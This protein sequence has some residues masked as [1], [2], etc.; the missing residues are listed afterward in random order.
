MN[1]EVRE[2]SGVDRNQV[3]IYHHYYLIIQNLRKIISYCSSTAVIST[4]VCAW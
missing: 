3:I 1:Y 2:M 4:E